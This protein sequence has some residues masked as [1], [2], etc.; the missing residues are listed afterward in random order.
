MPD[1]RIIVSNT[2]VIIGMSAIDSIE[3]LKELYNE[4]FISEEVL[5]E[6]KK[7]KGRPGFDIYKKLWINVKAVSNPKLKEYLCLNLDEGEACTIV[8]AEE[9]NAEL[10]LMDDY[11]GRKIAEYRNLKVTGT[12]G[13]ISRAKNEGIINKVKPLIDKLIQS[14]FWIGDN[15]YKAVLK[16]NNEL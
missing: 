3:I 11:W 9:I 8:L 4:I 1:S 12:L 2:T 7:G 14:G 15:L 13:I 10:V 16:Q 5:D 6:L